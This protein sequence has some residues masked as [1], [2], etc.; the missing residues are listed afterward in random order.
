MMAGLGG[1]F[2]SS[3]LMPH[4]FCLLWQ[5]ELLALHVSSDVVTGLSYYSI[6]VALVYFVRKRRDLAFSWVFWLFAA[7]ILACG[8]THLFSIWTLWQP[9][10]AVEGLIKAVTAIVSMLTAVALWMLMPKALAL[11]SPSQL[12]VA[13][14]ALH[15]EITERRQ[16]E[17]RYTSFFNN[18][19]EGLFVIG[20]RPDGGFVLET[21]NPAHARATGLDPA[22][23][24]GRTVEE[25]LP[26]EVADAV[27]ARYR[28]C[29][30]AGGPI[31]YEEDLDLPVGRRIWHT[32]LV[33]VR[34]EGGRIVQLLGSGR[35]VTERK[36]LQDE[37][38]QASKL[39]TLG[40][41][42][43]GMAH[44]MSQ[45]L[46]VI[47]TWAENALSRLRDGQLDGARTEKVLVLVGE[48]TERMG[49][50]IDHM[51]TFSRRDGGGTQPFDP[52]R[53]V[54]SAVE[55]VRHHYGL[56][57]II[58]TADVQEAACIARGRPLQL[59]QVVLNLLSN[60]RDAIVDERARGRA[61]G[62][63]RIDVVFHAA[64]HS[65]TA[66]ISVTDDGGGVPAEILP[67]IFDP[68]FTTKEVGQGSGLG[69]SIGYGIIDAMGGRIV[70]DNVEH[71]DGRRGVRFTITLPVS[72]PSQREVEFAHA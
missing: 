55:M 61:A 26:P 49:R 8:T 52:A 56:E 46:N 12:A 36:H 13:N 69:L 16:V 71:G 6:P 25:A 62:V 47:R 40:T 58:L 50:I 22:Q 29:V 34:D 66:V 14:Q 37:L 17:E 68:F 45:P 59:E 18:L 64:A 67:R 19:A 41:L 28:E 38:V 48:Q 27:I 35:D 42:A 1:I 33:P 65:H 43:A 15:R 3:A 21:L 2:D 39:A 53:S 54:R 63:G 44:E 51:R 4:G 57:G 23:V 30:A 32:V 20:V 9:D 11:P 24:C 31:D 72:R 60:A 5:P 7:F 10:Y 70:A